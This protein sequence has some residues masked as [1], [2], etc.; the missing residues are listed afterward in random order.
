M[1]FTYSIALASIGMGIWI[2]ITTQKLN[3]T[4]AVFG[5]FVVGALL[6]QPVTG[7]LHH[8]L[9]KRQDGPNAATYPHIWWGRAIVTLGM[10]NGG[11]GFKLSDN[12]PSGVIAYRIISAFMWVAWMAVIV[13]AFLKSKKE[14]MLGGIQ[15]EM[16]VFDQNREKLK[17]RDGSRPLP[18]SPQLSP[19]WPS[20]AG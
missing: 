16:A 20:F 6:L 12:S 2:A 1:G 18:P 14:H 15:T 11:L 5:L 10:I 8:S 9:F 3:T 19:Y 13:M 4:H 17:D 7:L